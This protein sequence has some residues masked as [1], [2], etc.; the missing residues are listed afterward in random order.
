MNNRLMAGT[1][2]MVMHTAL[3]MM[4]AL[5]MAL[6]ATMPALAVVAPQPTY[7][8]AVVDGSYAEW[9]LT[10]DFFAYMYR[11]GNPSKPI[12]SSLYL[13]YDCATS[14]GYAL[15]LAQSGV[16][17][18]MQPSDAFVKLGNSTKLVD[19]NSATFA[20]V[21]PSAQTGRAQGWEASFSLAP[22]SYSNLNV[23]TQVFDE[24]SQTSAVADRSIPILI[25][26]PVV[27]P[28]ETPTETPDPASG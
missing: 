27:P 3:T 25:E 15:V 5:V 6:M 28:T 4:L 21:Q 22:G 8:T 1:H 2:K 7:G 24:E 18:L 16:D 10:D 11:A 14:T 19:G 12:E 23:H 17:V 9:N 13:R 20:W 26:C